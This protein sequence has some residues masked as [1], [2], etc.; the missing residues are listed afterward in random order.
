M[1][2][3]YERLV[4]KAEKSMWE[5]FGQDDYTLHGKV[6]M[7]EILKLA[8]LKRLMDK[9]ADFVVVANADSEELSVSAGKLPC[10]SLVDNTLQSTIHFGM[11]TGLVVQQSTDV[12]ERLLIIIDQEE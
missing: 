5:S 12:C 7:K 6:E 11:A 8:S 2:P 1:I 3:T 10:L 9:N 4:K